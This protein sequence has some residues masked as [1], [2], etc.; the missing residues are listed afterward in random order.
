M[1]VWRGRRPPV[2]EDL[3]T[4]SGDGKAQNI[5]IKHGGRTDENALWVA[6]VPER[7]PPKNGNIERPDM[8]ANHVHGVFAHIGELADCN[9]R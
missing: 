2:F 7:E 5:G 4:A 9:A 8:F 3:C 1:T 6:A